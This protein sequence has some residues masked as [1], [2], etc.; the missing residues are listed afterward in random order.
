MTL[1]RLG[2]SEKDTVAAEQLAADT[3]NELLEQMRRLNDYMALM[4]D[5]NQPPTEPPTT[6]TDDI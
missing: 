4:N 2:R 5:T 1:S 3:Q 6:D